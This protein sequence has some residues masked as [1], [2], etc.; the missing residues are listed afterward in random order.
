MKKTV[1]E[2]LRRAQKV[3]S[4]QVGQEAQV[5]VLPRKSRLSKKR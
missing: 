3:R 4:H 2:N 5:P 1:K